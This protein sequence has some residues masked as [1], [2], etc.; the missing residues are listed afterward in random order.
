[1]VLTVFLGF[2]FTLLQGIEYL[3]VWFGIRDSSYGST[4]F[5][6]TGFHGTHVIVGT[7]F[8]L[9]CTLRFYS[10]LCP[11]DHMFGFEAAA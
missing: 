9:V 4:F 3:E 1:M 2:Y 8:L 10:L 5:M 11:A 6:G 7:L